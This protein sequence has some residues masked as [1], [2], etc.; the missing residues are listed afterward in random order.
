MEQMIDLGP[1][2]EDFV[3]GGGGGKKSTYVPFMDVTGP[4][5]FYP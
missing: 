3:T 5:L 2:I 1:K 4:L